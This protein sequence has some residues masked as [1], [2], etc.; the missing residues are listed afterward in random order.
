MSKRYII[1]AVSGLTS[2]LT[3]CTIGEGDTIAE[4][5][6]DAMGEKPWTAQMRRRAKDYYL[7]DTHTPT[8]SHS[9][10]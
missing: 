2:W 8:D 6:E 3:Y 1:Q 5:W 7:R 10:A 9:K 4:A